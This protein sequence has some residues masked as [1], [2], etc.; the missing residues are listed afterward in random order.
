MATL[1]PAVSAGLQT[2][3]IEVDALRS[4]LRSLRGGLGRALPLVLEAHRGVVVTGIGKS[5]LIGRKIAATLTSTGTRAVFMHPV[6]ALH[7]DLGVYCPGDVTI[8]LSNSGSTAELLRLVPI[9]RQFGSPM[10]GILGN[11]SSELAGNMDVVL[12][13]SVECE[14]DPLNIA[15]TSSAIVALALGDALASALMVARG[16]THED[17]ARCHPGGQLGR[18]LLLTVA[19][20]MHTE[21]SLAW[22]G[23]EASAKDLVVAM[24]E[25]P[26]GAACVVGPDRCLLG[27]VTDGDLRR[28]F[29]R[30]DDIRELSAK[31][32]MTTCPVVVVPGASLREALALMEDRSSQI[33][34]LPV[35][36][37]ASGGCLGLLRLHDVFGAK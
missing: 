36:D 24:T 14:A 34:V 5:G 19:D 32:I 3:S 17:Y 7:G 12:D 11:V 21:E 15:P 29:H 10:I 35:V 2:V 23:P 13:A 18:N 9:L 8:M 31:D 1:D 4:A 20:V 37:A 6:E 27:L 25:R 33:S 16:F 22:V 26:L 30:C 28:A